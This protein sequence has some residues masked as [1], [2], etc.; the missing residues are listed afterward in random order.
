MKELIV[1]GAGGFGRELLHWIK[2][3]NREHKKWIIK[4]FIDD[5]LGALDG[6]ECDY[7]VIG[8]IDSWQPGPAEVFA[9]A[10][11]HP[12]TK[13]Q[14]VTELKA[15]G[16]FFENIIHPQASTGEFNKIGEGL[17]M[18]P[19]A[20]LTVNVTIGNFVTLLSSAGH[21]VTIGDYSTISSFCGLNGKV[22][23]GKRVFLGSHVAIVPGRKIGDDAF[24]AAGSVVVSN[25]KPN[26]KVMGNPAKTMQF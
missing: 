20:N 16:A 5:N 12:Q 6:Y 13:E 26:K 22:Q 21:D 7:Q 19:K 11:A 2:A 15:R 4:G 10:I 23:I 14:V 17:V 18:Y 8:R 9:C 25:V 1:V 24:I 3:I